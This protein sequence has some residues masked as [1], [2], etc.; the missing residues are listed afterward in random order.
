MHLGRGQTIVGDFC[1]HAADNLKCKHP[2]HAQ[3]QDARTPTTMFDEKQMT[4]RT[5]LYIAIYI[6]SFRMFE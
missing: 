1:P 2:A 5:L 6:F 3:R 4:K